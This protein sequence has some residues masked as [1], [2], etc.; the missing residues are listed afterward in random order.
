MLPQPVG[1]FILCIAEHG[2]L[3]NS[4]GEK[5]SEKKVEKEKKKEK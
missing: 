4:E 5:K 2:A 1:N 3:A